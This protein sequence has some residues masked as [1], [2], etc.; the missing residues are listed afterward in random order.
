MAGASRRLYATE[1][2]DALVAEADSYRAQGFTA[3]KLRFGYGPRDGVRGKRRN[4]ELVRTVRSVRL[5]V[6][7]HGAQSGSRL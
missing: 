7:P 2:L 6:P 5:L 3:I 4:V 1:D